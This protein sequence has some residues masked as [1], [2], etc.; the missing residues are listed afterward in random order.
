[1][2]TGHLKKL[3][4]G[5]TLS[6]SVMMLF[7]CLGVASAEA[8]ENVTKGDI[9]LGAYLSSTCAGCHSGSDTKSGIPPLITLAPEEIAAALKAYK[10]GARDNPTMRTIAASL[11][12]NDVDALVAYFA[13]EHHRYAK[14]K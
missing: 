12:D 14:T 13:Q 10:T 2:K 5:R 6:L 4:V 11:S 1:M 3:T 9:A 8:E 7:I